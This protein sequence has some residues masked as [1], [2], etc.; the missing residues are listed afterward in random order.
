MLTASN[1]TKSATYSSNIVVLPTS[2]V[3][4]ASINKLTI[5]PNPTRGKTIIGLQQKFNNKGQIEI[6]SILGTRVYSQQINLNGTSDIELD[7]THIPNGLYAVTANFNGKIF[8]G[9]IV[10]R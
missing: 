2:I 8:K 4:Q 10:K 5:S 9:I 3:S 7:I 6:H 1:T